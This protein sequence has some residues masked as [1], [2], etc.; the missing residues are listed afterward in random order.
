MVTV[1][2]ENTLK[3]SN[4]FILCMFGC[5]ELCMKAFHICNQILENQPLCHIWY[6]KNLRL[7]QNIV[8]HKSLFH[9]AKHESV[10]W[11]VRK[12]IMLVCVLLWKQGRVMSSIHLFHARQSGLFFKIYATKRIVFLIVKLCV[13]ICFIVCIMLC[14]RKYAAWSK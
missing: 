12:I 13:S 11:I 10:W 2:G 8:L 14:N 7:K 1:T 9:W 5:L 4:E 3:W 6:S